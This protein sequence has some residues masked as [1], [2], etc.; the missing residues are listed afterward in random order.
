MSDVLTLAEVLLLIEALEDRFNQEVKYG[1]PFE[2]A[3]AMVHVYDK[4][5]RYEGELRKC[6]DS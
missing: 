3:L 4:L 1:L 2:E 6:L 5:K